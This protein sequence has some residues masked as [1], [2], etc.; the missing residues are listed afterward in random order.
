V[1]KKKTRWSMSGTDRMVGGKR[2]KR[3]SDHAKVFGVLFEK[4]LEGGG[5]GKGGYRES[6]SLRRVMVSGGGGS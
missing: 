4:D 5:R 6:R 1:G 2:R 3:D